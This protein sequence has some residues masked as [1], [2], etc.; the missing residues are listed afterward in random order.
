MGI[1]MDLR[2]IQEFGLIGYG[3]RWLVRERDRYFED[4]F[5]DLGLNMWVDLVPLQR[6]EGFGIIKVMS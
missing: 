3:S 6:R 4:D 5:Q 1:W 2:D